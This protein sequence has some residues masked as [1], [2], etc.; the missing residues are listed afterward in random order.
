MS[1]S[2]RYYQHY[3]NQVHASASGQCAPPPPPLPQDVQ[4]RVSG[5]YYAPPPPPLPQNVQT[6]VSDQYYAPPPPPLPLQDVQ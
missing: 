4:A 3:R 5:Q 6:R 2:F 1:Y